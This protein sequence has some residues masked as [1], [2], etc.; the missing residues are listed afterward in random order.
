MTV[1]SRNR[2]HVKRLLVS[3][4]A[5]GL[6]GCGDTFGPDRDT[7]A[8]GEYQMI[9]WAGV[10]LPTSTVTTGTLQI[11]DGAATF[12]VQF[13][14]G[15]ATERQD[16]RVSFTRAD[17]TFLIFHIGTPGILYDDTLRVGAPQPNVY[18]RTSR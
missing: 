11:R 1:F 18:V 13:S 17:T 7:L 15:P 9:R 2:C 4:V 10:T 5:V 3:V 8:D 16:V 12:T 6:T 14:A